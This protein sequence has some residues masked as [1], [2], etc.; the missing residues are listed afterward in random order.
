VLLVSLARA[1]G[2]PAAIAFQHI[3]DHKLL[4]PRFARLLPDGIIPFHGLTM[5][6]LDGGWLRVDPTLDRRLCAER[7]YRLVAFD[8][9]SEALLPATDRD[10]R[11]HFE[12]LGE[13][14]PFA[15][16]PPAVSQAAVDLEPVW[17]ELRAQVRRKPAAL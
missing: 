11:P 9:R 2:I 15:D 16:L 14:G 12:L 10:G 1:A 13:L 6:H 8:G 5:L 4:E 3:R 17:T 7:G